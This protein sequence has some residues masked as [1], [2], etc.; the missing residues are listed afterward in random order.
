M[1]L[2]NVI[3]IQ[4]RDY[5]ENMYESPNTSKIEMPEAW[6]DFWYKCISDSNLQDLKSI[7]TGSYLVDTNTIG[8]VEL[9]TIL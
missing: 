4:P 7:E 2:L 6:N 8:D 5:T 1:K 9:K 3:E